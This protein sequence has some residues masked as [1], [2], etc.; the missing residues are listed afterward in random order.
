MRE[1]VPRMNIFMTH[2][3]YAVDYHFHANLPK[4]EKRALQKCHR[5]WQEF[6][7]KGVN[8]VISTEHVYKN[9]KR[10][11]QMMN[12]TKPDDMHIFPGMEYLT[13]EGIDI[14]IFSERP[15]LYDHDVLKPYQLT[16]DQILDFVLEHHLTAFIT[17]PHTLGTTSVIRKSTATEYE[18]YVNKIKSIEITNT[19]FNELLHVITKPIFRRFF[20]KKINEIQ[21]N[22]NV[23]PQY[24]PKEIQLLTAGSDAHH[25]AEVGTHVIIESDSKKLFQAITSNSNA[26]VIERAIT[27]TNFL[28]L[29]RSAI[30]CFSE[31]CIKFKIRLFS[32][33]IE[34][35]KKYSS[36]Y[37]KTDNI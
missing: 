6:R 12:A 30:T 14:I 2:S 37:P 1:L 23:P 3:K 22:R 13:K 10:A 35:F 7:K 11:Y 31:A 15:D 36:I 29:L 26:V 19:A 24:Y 20:S 4:S 9:P 18:R 5:W 28:L 17:H 25:F 27:Q 8:V 32:R 34:F 33:K 16:Y 21:K